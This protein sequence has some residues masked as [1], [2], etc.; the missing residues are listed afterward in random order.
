[1][2][3]V[4]E[5]KLNQVCQNISIFSNIVHLFSGTI[6]PVSVHHYDGSETTVYKSKIAALHP[7]C[8]QLL[9]PLFLLF[10]AET[11]VLLHLGML[12]FANCF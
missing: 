10:V 12:L 11:M 1:M 2:E 3:K 9:H 7:F 4:L 8:Y 6:E 5:L